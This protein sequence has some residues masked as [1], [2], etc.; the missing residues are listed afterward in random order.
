[1]LLANN[2]TLQEVTNQFDLA[3]SKRIRNLNEN[4][5]DIAMIYYKKAILAI[6][7]KDLLSCKAYLEKSIEI[8]NNV[9]TEANIYCIIF[10][11]N[12]GNLLICIEE[13]DD[14]IYFL[15]RELRLRILFKDKKK[16]ANC[17]KRIGEALFKKKELQKALSYMEIGVS[18]MNELYGEL[19]A[20]SKNFFQIIGEI[21]KELGNIERAEENF[22]KAF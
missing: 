1:L 22:S 12:V 4:H 9:F 15:E 6:L 18:L 11:R 16:I 3:F 17:Y 5:L 20:R 21:Y 10:Y 7:V 13:L 2:C 19:D 8:L 14:G